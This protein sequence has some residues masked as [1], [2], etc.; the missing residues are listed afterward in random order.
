MSA[1]GRIIFG[2]FPPSS[3]VTRFKLLEAWLI[4]C[5][6]T[7]VEHV[8]AILFTRGW[9]TNSTPVSPKTITTLNN[10]SEKQASCVNF[11]IYNNESCVCYVCFK[12]IVQIVASA[13]T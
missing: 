1:S 4:M 11:D 8:K 13:D 3:N 7:S 6:P 5:L 12:I 9:L 2:D 10:P